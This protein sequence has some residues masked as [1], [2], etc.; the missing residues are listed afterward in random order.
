MMKR[1]SSFRCSRILVIVV[2]CG[3]VV[4][5]AGQPAGARDEK[6]AKQRP[7]VKTRLDGAWRLVSS[8]DPRTGQ[9]RGMPP[10]VEMTKLLVGG[11]YAWTAVR[12]GKAIFGAGGKYQV[13]EH[14]YTETV[15]YSVGEN[16]LSLVG[17]ACPFTWT[18]ED[19]KWHHKGTLKVGASRQEINE[20]WEPVP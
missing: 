11:Q 18:I 6:N 1:V 4:S 2:G 3:L 12:D 9:M 7:Q 10:G 17:V 13:D 8:R 5:H 19:G 20:I 14:T 15:V 16:M